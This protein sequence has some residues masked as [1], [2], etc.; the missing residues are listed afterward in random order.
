[1]MQGGGGRMQLAH[2][3]AIF[4][5]KDRVRRF[6]G[7]L[8]IGGRESEFVEFLVGKI[9]AYK[10][11]IRD[12]EFV[13]SE[14]GVRFQSFSKGSFDFLKR[15]HGEA[16]ETWTGQ[17]KL[18]RFTGAQER[19]QRQRIFSNLFQYHAQT[20]S[21]ARCDKSIIIAP[22]I[23]P[24]FRVGYDFIEHGDFEFTIAKTFFRDWIDGG[25]KGALTWF[26]LRAELEKLCARRR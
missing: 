25:I 3:P 24:G 16:N 18:G 2:D 19:G 13:L 23:D 5:S 22:K 8:Q 14:V 17:G 1:M 15:H 9:F 21:N 26:S 4:A 10:M 6:G 20:R 11:A 12:G 7:K